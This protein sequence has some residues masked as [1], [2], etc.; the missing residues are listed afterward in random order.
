MSSSDR[1]S[2]LL[3]KHDVNFWSSFFGIIIGWGVMI[4][5]GGG[6]RTI[7]G[8]T[9]PDRRGKTGEGDGTTREGTR[10]TTDEGSLTGRR[11][12]DSRTEAPVSRPKG[13]KTEWTEGEL[14]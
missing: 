11:D 12:G 13:G 1:Y 4:T 2:I 9:C 8:R 14:R 3:D 6:N 7:D 5:T 10:E